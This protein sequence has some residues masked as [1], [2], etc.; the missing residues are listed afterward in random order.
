MDHAAAVNEQW[1]EGSA[2]TRCDMRGHGTPFDIPNGIFF[3]QL[4]AIPASP[5]LSLISPCDDTL[6]EQKELNPQPPSQLTDVEKNDEK[7]MLQMYRFITENICDSDP[8]SDEENEEDL[9]TTDDSLYWTNVKIPREQSTYPLPQLLYPL[10][11]QVLPEENLVNLNRRWEKT[12]TEQ[13]GKNRELSICWLDFPRKTKSKGTAAGRKVR[14]RKNVSFEVVV[15]PKEREVTS[16]W[17][18]KQT[19]AG[20]LVISSEHK[21]PKS[22]KAKLNQMQNGSQLGRDGKKFFMSMGVSS[23]AVYHGTLQRRTPNR[24]KRKNKGDETECSK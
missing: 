1:S 15:E 10:E 24:S 18:Q 9:S 11:W 8:D 4:I 17:L 5:Y 3:H 7:E 16:F 21:G 22:K 19:Q 6:L 20:N 14:K 12:G 23:K 2:H 13:E